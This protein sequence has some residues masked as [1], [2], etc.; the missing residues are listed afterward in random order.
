MVISR[1]KAGVFHLFVHAAW[2]HFVPPRLA[3]PPRPANVCALGNQ[4]NSGPALLT[5]GK[6]K[7]SASTSAQVPVFQDS[8]LANCSTS[9]PLHVGPL[10]VP[11]NAQPTHDLR[12]FCGV[13]TRKSDR[14]IKNPHRFH[15][16]VPSLFVK[17]VA[18]KSD[19]HEHGQAEST[20]A[21]RLASSSPPSRPA[22]LPSRTGLAGGIKK[23]HRFHSG[24][25]ALRE[26]RR[27][28]KRRHPR[29]QDR[30]PAPASYGRATRCIR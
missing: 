20:G 3:V 13:V 16:G 8:E 7:W 1:A 29:P 30:W 25:V 15:P 10:V 17:F 21:R 12:R 18:T 6:A 4:F 11:L 23:P 9:K 5:G 27:Y 19:G 14:G 24:T 22:S 26:I 28:Q 2:T